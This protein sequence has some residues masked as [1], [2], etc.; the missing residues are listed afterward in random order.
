MLQ[1]KVKV[2]FAG[3]KGFALNQARFGSYF[4]LPNPKSN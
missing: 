3:K 4:N 1:L 2:L